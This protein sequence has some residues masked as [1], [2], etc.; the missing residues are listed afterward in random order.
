MQFSNHKCDLNDLFY[1]KMQ[2]ATMKSEK[3]VK[4]VKKNQRKIFQLQFQFF[5]A[6]AK[7]KKKIDTQELGEAFFC[8]I[9]R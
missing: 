7:Q 1:F 2:T 5:K 4:K 8:Q 3:R 6:R 9:A